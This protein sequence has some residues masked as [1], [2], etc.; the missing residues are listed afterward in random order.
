MKKIS[1]LSLFVC[2]FLSPV[3][4]DSSLTLGQFLQVYFS[5]A[6]QSVSIPNSYTSIQ[7]KFTNISPK[8]PLYPLIQKAIYLD[9]FPNA[10]MELPLTQKITRLQATSILQK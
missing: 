7:P 8:N 3:F 1:F 4:A 2:I 10:R 5:V 9:I 6:T